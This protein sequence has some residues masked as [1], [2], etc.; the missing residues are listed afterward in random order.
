MAFPIKTYASIFDRTYGPSYDEPDNKGHYGHLIIRDSNT[1]FKDYLLIGCNKNET[2]A[3]E[4][5]IRLNRQQAKTVIRAI[6]KW[7]KRIGDETKI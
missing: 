6:K 2:D 3:I 5:G 7:L 1:A 4:R